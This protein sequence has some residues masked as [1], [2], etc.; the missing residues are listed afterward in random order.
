[1]PKEAG[2]GFPPSKDPTVWLEYTGP[3]ADKVRWIQFF[4]FEIEPITRFGSFIS[5]DTEHPVAGFTFDL[6]DAFSGNTELKNQTVTTSTWTKRDYH[7]LLDTRTDASPY[8]YDPGKK[9][10]GRRSY[11]FQ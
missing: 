5:V 9:S 10:W 11:Q 6:K 4:S 8:Y 2:D 3:G 1:M 7:F